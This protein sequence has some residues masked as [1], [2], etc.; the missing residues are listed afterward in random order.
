MGSAFS[1]RFAAVFGSLGLALGRRR[2]GGQT[3]MERAARACVEVFPLARRPGPGLGPASQAPQFIR[4]GREHG[5]RVLVIPGAPFGRRLLVLGKVISPQ[6]PQSA[7]FG[8]VNVVHGVL[9]GCQLPG[10]FHQSLARTRAFRSQIGGAYAGISSRFPA[11]R[12]RRSTVSP[13]RYA[14]P[15]TFSAGT[16]R[17]PSAIVDSWPSRTS[18]ASTAWASSR[19][20]VAFMMAA[21]A[22]RVQRRGRLARGLV[23][24]R[25]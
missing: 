16:G 19:R 8:F 6:L 1:L 25:A 5:R 9:A 4:E 2:P 13:S 11:T 23:R 20:S 12:P 24:K 7:A 18:R 15:W 22:F 3:T 17:L 14:T 10:S 21:P